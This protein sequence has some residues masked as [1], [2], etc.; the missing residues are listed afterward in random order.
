VADGGRK[1]NKDKKHTT[2]SK[3][4]S[5]R[6]VRITCLRWAACQLIIRRFLRSRFRVLFPMESNLTGPLK[7]KDRALNC[8]PGLSEEEDREIDEEGEN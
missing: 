8:C 6:N 5:V 7:S 3:L 1:Q 2:E 4:K